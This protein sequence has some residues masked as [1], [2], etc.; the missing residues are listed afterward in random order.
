VLVSKRALAIFFALIATLWGCGRIGYEHLAVEKDTG[1]VGKQ[2]NGFYIDGGK[3]DKADSSPET[4]GAFANSSGNSVG[5]GGVETSI[6]ASTAISGTGGTDTAT[7]SGDIDSQVDATEPT[8]GQDSA[9][10][11]DAEAEDAISS[12]DSATDAS[13]DAAV[14]DGAASCGGTVVFGLCWYITAFATSCNRHCASHGGFD[15]RTAS[16]I[17]TPSQGGS[18]NNCR[19]IL[20][21]LG[22]STNVA[23]GTQAS[24]GGFGCHVWSG[25][26]KWWLSSPNFVPSISG[27]SV[28]IACA[29]I[30]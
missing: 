11:S 16:Y 21:A 18:L 19:N 24:G 4:G 6:D 28:N 29:C 25:G 7:D 27:A 10:S 1:E 12:T 3:E 5:S 15:T 14:K 17:G 2:S 26:D 13:T 30:R 8:P 23:E 9:A 22:Y 20:G